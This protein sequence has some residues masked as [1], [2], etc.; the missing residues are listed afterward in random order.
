VTR[1][2]LDENVP[3][4]VTRE[5]LARGHDV[6]TVLSQDMGGAPDERVAGKCAE[7]QRVLITLD[8][9]FADVRSYGRPG[10]PAIVVVRVARQDAGSVAHTL[11]D[12]LGRLASEARPGTICI[13]EPGRIRTWRRDDAPSPEDA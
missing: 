6:E 3:A 12:A 5:L 10:S 7:E 8:L 4:R 13:V 1:F 2:K 9:D 11:C